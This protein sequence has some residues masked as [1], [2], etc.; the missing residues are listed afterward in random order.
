VWPA[1]DRPVKADAVVVLGGDGHRNAAGERLVREGVAP[2]LAVS[3]GSPDD[4]CFRRHEP[5]TLICFRPTPFTTQ[6][7]ARWIAA[8]AKAMGWRSVVVVVS[9]PQATRARV[10]IR[11]CYRGPLQVVGV[12]LGAT[13][14]IHDVFYEWGALLKAMTLQRSC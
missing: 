5:F 11:R 12:H 2:I 4:P 13:R 3:V 1:T 6:G 8:T 14:T 9:D 10:R 7:E